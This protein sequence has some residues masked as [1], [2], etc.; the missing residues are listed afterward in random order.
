MANL[1]FISPFL[2]RLY[3]TGIIKII[4]PVNKAIVRFR[5]KNRKL[6]HIV[7]INNTEGA[8]PL[9]A[10]SRSLRTM[11]SKIGKIK[12]PIYPRFII[13]SENKPPFALA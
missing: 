13:A 6:K 9:E 11:I 1:Q 4:P 7:I 12:A 8:K 10:P 5:F 3:K 2:G